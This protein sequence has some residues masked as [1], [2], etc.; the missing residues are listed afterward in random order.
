[1]SPTAIPS[2]AV[3]GRIS[4]QRALFV[5]SALAFASAELLTAALHES[6]HGLAAQFFGFSPHI[7]AFYENNPSGDACE[8][9]TILAAGGVRIIRS[10]TKDPGAVLV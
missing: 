1:M 4:P 8:T 10:S 7:Y 9:L 3:T 2:G 6:G 5:N